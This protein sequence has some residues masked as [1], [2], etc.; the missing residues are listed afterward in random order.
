MQIPL[1]SVESIVLTDTRQNLDSVHRLKD[2]FIYLKSVA[3]GYLWADFELFI[4]I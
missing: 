3:I 4:W 1:T 2:R